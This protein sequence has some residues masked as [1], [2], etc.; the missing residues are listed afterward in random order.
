MEQGVETLSG[1]GI[2]IYLNGAPHYP[3]RGWIVCSRA[4]K[5]GEGRWRGGKREVAMARAAETTLYRLS[6][7]NRSF[8]LGGTVLGR[9]EGNVDVFSLSCTHNG[10]EQR[11]EEQIRHVFK[12]NTDSLA[13]RQSMAEAGERCKG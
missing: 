9:Q 12:Y 10:S 8:I 4:G 13:S 1:T 6:K 3:A 7:G 2:K 11:A 5:D